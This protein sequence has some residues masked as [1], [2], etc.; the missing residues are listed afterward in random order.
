MRPHHH[1]A[2]SPSS[3]P[4][5]HAYHIARRAC[6]PSASGPAAP[7][8]GRAWPTSTTVL[9]TS[10]SPGTWVLILIC[11]AQRRVSTRPSHAPASFRHVECTCSLIPIIP[12]PSRRGP[13]RR[14]P[15]SP[16]CHGVRTVARYRPPP[17][18]PHWNLDEPANFYGRYRPRT[19]VT[20]RA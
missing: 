6:A 1:H 17:T 16:A 11:N 19:C 14:R 12:K 13:T 18:P 15:P 2:P 3:S 9:G 7:Y 10:A 5:S 20:Q 4:S 8:A